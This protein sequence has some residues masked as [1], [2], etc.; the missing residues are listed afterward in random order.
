MKRFYKSVTVDRAPEGYRILLDGK[1]VKTPGRN[2]LLLPRDALAQSIADEWLAQTDEITPISM[3]MLRMANTAIDGVTQNRDAV[4]AAILRFGEHDAVC[5]RATY[6]VDLV[7]RQQEAWAPMLEWAASRHDAQLLVTTGLGHIEQSPEA[8]ARLRDA[9]AA[10]DD[11]A[12]AALHVMASITGSLVLGLALA[13]GAIN[14]AQAFQMSRLDEDYQV[15][16]WG[17]DAEAEARAQALAREMDV[18]IR[19]LEASRP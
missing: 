1:P 7:M 2:A 3:P 15:G 17:R 18:A 13:E 9:V 8:L 5:Y 6:P 16:Q 14:A 19:F 10:H 11:F 12:L 4:I